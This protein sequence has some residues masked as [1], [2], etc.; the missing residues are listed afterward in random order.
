MKVDFIGRVEY[1]KED[2]KKMADRFN[3]VDKI[4]HE[5]RSDTLERDYDYR[6]Y[7]D[8]GLAKMVYR[9]YRNDVELLGYKNDYIRL[10]DYL[11]N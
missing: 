5:N 9:R 2:W 11:S 8:V 6:K 4:P 1:I 7:Y 10:L 3:F